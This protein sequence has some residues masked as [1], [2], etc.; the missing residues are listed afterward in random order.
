[1]ETPGDVGRVVEPGAYRQQRLDLRRLICAAGGGPGP[2]TEGAAQ[3]GALGDPCTRASL[4]IQYRNLHSTEQDSTVQCTLVLHVPLTP[5]AA[6]R[7][8]LLEQTSP[9]QL[10]KY[11]PATLPVD[12]GAAVLFYLQSGSHRA[13]VWG[14]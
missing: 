6:E 12:S 2:G 13:S 7:N 3:K 9:V 5:A 1:M 11:C 10:V 4:H 8:N 14:I